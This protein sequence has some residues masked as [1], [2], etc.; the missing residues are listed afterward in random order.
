MRVLVCPLDWG[1]GHATRCIPL[2]RALRAA[3]HAV[4]PYASGAGRGLLQAEFPD[5]PVGNLA[6]YPM[7]YARSRALQ[8]V[9]LFGQLP[10]LLLSMLWDRLCVKGLIRRHAIDLVLSDGRYGLRTSQGPLEVVTCRMHKAR[11]VL[12]KPFAAF[13]AFA[14]PSP[15][16]NWHP[17]FARDLR[18]MPGR[19]LSQSS[20]CSPR[21]KASS[22]RAATRAGSSR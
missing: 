7:R 17:A 15:T 16:T 18:G 14:H 11:I 12:S 9:W 3:G 6:S 13:L 19:R 1:L 4:F 5:L 10:F 8:P 20:A 2:I 21:A 22:H